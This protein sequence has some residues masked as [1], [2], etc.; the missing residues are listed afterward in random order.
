MRLSV[1]DAKKILENAPED[2]EV[3]V[4]PDGFTVVSKDKEYDYAD[5]KYQAMRGLYG[6]GFTTPPLKQKS[7]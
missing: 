5:A 2:H 4:S 6:H 3:Q 7:S 1:K